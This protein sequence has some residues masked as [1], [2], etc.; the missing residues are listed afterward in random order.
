MNRHLRIASALAICVVAY[1]FFN[2]YAPLI[3]RLPYEDKIAHLVISAVLVVLV[4]WSLGLTF[5]RSAF[6]TTLI[7]ICSELVQY[8]LPGRTPSLVDFLFD[9]AGV[10]LGVA[11]LTLFEKFSSP[12]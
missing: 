8:L 3:L 4:V 9:L 7:G 2:S 11:G 6:L 5:F 1:V 12:R 10:A